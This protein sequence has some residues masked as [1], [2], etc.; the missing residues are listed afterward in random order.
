MVSWLPPAR[1]MS[2]QLVSRASRLVIVQR[3]CAN[4]WSRVTFNDNVG[5]LSSLLPHA[6]TPLLNQLLVR[7][8]ATRPAKPKAHT[9]RASAS[10][11]R[12]P[13]VAQSDVQAGVPKKAPAKRTTKTKKT[14]AKKRVRKSKPKTTA[15]ATPKRKRLT[16][17]QKAVRSKKA[18]IQKK[19]DLKKQALLDYPKRL[20]STPF[21]VLSTE[22]STKGSSAAQNAKAISAQYKSLRP[23]EMEVLLHPSPSPL[24]RSRTD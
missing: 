8:Y 15:E 19:K 2:H 3:Q 13:A 24:L 9:G 12:K 14:A 11:K 23:E 7:C 21:I 20:P 16:E 6:S 10:K 1:A 4:S 5:F 17:K 18:V 22:S